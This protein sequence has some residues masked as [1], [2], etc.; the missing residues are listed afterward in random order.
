[1]DEQ[2]L[3]MRLQE[4]HEA[5]FGWALRCSGWRPEEAEDLLQT[6]YLKVLDGRARY[7]GRAAF[8][9]WLF[10]VIHRTA[11][12][13]RRRH[14]LQKLGLARLERAHNSSVSGDRPVENLYQSQIQSVLQK[15]LSKLPR[16]QQE[17]LHLVFYQDMSLS[18]A[19]EI[20]GVTI[21]SARTHYERG[22]QRLREL[23]GPK[24]D[25]HESR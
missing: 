21:G 25:F 12:G 19:A 24:E 18:E 11:A 8:K 5:S 9:T 1:M 6:A 14:W 20:M 16:R 4:L 22:K 15:A 17:A 23:I 7:D 3:R 10:A 13:E 2:E